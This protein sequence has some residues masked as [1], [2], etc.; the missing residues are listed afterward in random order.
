MD[1][2]LEYYT[3]PS[4]VDYLR[5]VYFVEE[6]EE[7]EESDPPTHQ[8]WLAVALIQLICQDPLVSNVA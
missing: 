1:L 8:L 7:S 6:S 3:A 5:W 4:I 2:L